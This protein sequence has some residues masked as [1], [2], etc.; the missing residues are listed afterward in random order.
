MELEKEERAGTI[1]TSETASLERKAAGELQIPL[2]P[3]FSLYARTLIK[4]LRKYA[5][6][7]IQRVR[8]YALVMPSRM[9]AP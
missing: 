2:R 4:A 8:L 1:G 6:D 7:N 3:S 5:Y 9:H